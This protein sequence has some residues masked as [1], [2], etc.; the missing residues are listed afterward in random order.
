MPNDL[1]RRLHRAAVAGRIL[2]GEVDV[3]FEHLGNFRLTHAADLPSPDRR[4]SSLI[5]PSLLAN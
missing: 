5:S 2:F 1:A 4:Q 3:S